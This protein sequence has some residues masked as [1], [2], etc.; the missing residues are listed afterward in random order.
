MRIILDGLPDR[1]LIC[2]P[3]RWAMRAFTQGGLRQLPGDAVTADLK[4]NPEKRL[5]VSRSMPLERARDNM[6]RNGRRPGFVDQYLQAI[7]TGGETDGSA[8]ELVREHAFRER[9][10]QIASDFSALP[11]DRSF[12][13]AWRLS[14]QGVVIDLP[15][16]RTIF[17]RQFIHWKTRSTLELGKR[18]EINL[19]AGTTDDQIEAQYEALRTLNLR[20][21]G[22]KVIAAKTP[23]ELKAICPDCLK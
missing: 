8:L 12:R 18:I 22:D 19:V 5:E 1:L 4:E 11:S 6:I 3:T 15:A 16:A 13:N 14:G 21:I 9:T 2:K 10:G 23:E 20:S 7:L 17:A